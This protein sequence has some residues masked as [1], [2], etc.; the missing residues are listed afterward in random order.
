ME[1]DGENNTDVQR[2]KKIWGR[3]EKIIRMFC[4]RREYGEGWR[5]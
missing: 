1:K 5:K 4:V 2:K 3:I